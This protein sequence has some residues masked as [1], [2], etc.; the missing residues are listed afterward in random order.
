METTDCRIHNWV[1]VPTGGEIK[2][3]CYPKRVLGITKFGEFDFTE[4]S[5]PE[6]HIVPAKH[7][8][9]IRLT[10]KLLLKL[11][12]KKKHPGLPNVYVLVIDV[13]SQ[14]GIELQEIENGFQFFVE[15]ECGINTIDVVFEDL[16]QLQNLYLD[17]NHK[18]LI[19]DPTVIT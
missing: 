16:H 12:F 11:G 3:P 2:I 15:D 4:P 7:C 14:T 13:H 17:L 5:Y 18:E 1:L 8:A 9:G 10:E 19:I 6:N